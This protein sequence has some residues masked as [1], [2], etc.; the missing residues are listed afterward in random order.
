[1]KYISFFG[2]DSKTGATSIAYCV[3]ERLS[4]MNYKTLMIFASGRSSRSLSGK[5]FRY[6][7]DDIKAAIISGKV[8]ADD[9]M[10]ITE[11]VGRLHVINDVRNTFTSKLFPLDTFERLSIIGEYYDYVVID[12]GN[13]FE[14]AM[15]VSAL[16]VSH[17]CFFLLN[18]NQVSIG[19]FIETDEYVLRQMNKDIEIILNMCRKNIA[20][21]RKKEIE[22][23]VKRE[24][25][26]E[27]PYGGDACMYDDS[28]SEILS[29]KKCRKVVNV[30]AADI[31]GRPDSKSGNGFFS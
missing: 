19:R 4:S 20:L 11:K 15:T 14:N 2:G 16:N 24:I 21:H 12:A 7:I 8:T 9:V 5:N 18:Q 29:K 22:A 17:Q 23:L 26:Y 1:M 25:R 10:H 27:I 13:R 31:A 3:A 6:S 28:F 30:I